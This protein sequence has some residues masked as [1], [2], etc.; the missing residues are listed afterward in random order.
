M[1]DRVGVMNAGRIEQIGTPAEIYEKPQTPF[2]ASF[3]GR[4]NRFRPGSREQGRLRH[5]EA[6]GFA[7]PPPAH[8]RSARVPRPWSARTASTCAR[9][10]PPKVR[11]NRSGRD[12]QG[13][14]RRRD[15]QYEIT[16]GGTT[17]ASRANLAGP[18]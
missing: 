5:L 11:Q 15:V 17:L 7:L 18:G 16:A 9:R 13:D 10:A 14:L 2:V 6:T 12:P 4:M 8:C 3:I 1:S